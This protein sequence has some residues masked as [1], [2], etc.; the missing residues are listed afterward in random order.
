MRDA[1]ELRFGR[2]LLRRAPRV[3]LA[4]GKPVRLGA[5][6]I[7][8]L[9][10]LVDA[11][12][13]PVSKEE[14]MHR[15]WPQ[16]VVEEHNLTVQISALRAALG[17]DA[18]F[19][20]T[21]PRRGYAFT[22]SVEIVAAAPTPARPDAVRSGTA[23]PTNIPA[24]VSDLIGRESELL[25]LLELQRQRRLLT[26]TGPGGIGK[27]RLAVELA[28]RLL[29]E[30]DDGVWLLDLGLLGDAELLIASV[31]SVFGLQLAAA[32][33]TL[34]QVVTALAGKRLLLVLD[35]CEHL[36]V[37]AANM[38][39]VL[40]SRSASLAIVATSREQLRVNGESV[41]R[42]PP[43]GVPATALTLPDEILGC[44][45]ARLF[46]AR[47]RAADA[48]FSAD[49]VAGKIGAICRRL[50]GI[51]LAIELA[52]ARAVTLGA[53]EVLERLD[54]RFRL[55]T[56]GRRTA[57]P[58][59]Q[60]LRAALDWSYDLLGETEQSV[61]RGLGVFVGSF[62]LGAA[63]AVAGGTGAT[64]VATVECVANLVA[65]S[66]VSSTGEITDRR[67][68]LLE[69]TRS[70]MLTRLAEAGERTTIERRHAEYYRDLFSAGPGDPAQNDQH[71]TYA[72]EI[73]NIRAALDW[74]LFEGGD[75][76]I[77]IALAAALTPLWVRMSL[78]AEATR[79][80]RQALKLLD[81]RA[82]PRIEMVLNAAFGA[83]LTY[84]TGPGPETLAAWSKALRLAEDL[85][86][87]EYVLRA[88]RG[89]WSFRMNRGEY[90]SALALAN[91][92]CALV[93][94]APDAAALRAG[95]RMAGLILHYLGEQQEARR[96][97]ERG[98]ETADRP[99]QPLP[100]TRFMLN[101]TVAAR[102][103]LARIS[104]LQGFPDRAMRE[105]CDALRQAQLTGHAL[106]QCHALAQAACPVALWTGDL[107]AMDGFVTMLIDL[108]TLNAL[109]GWIARGKCFR[110]ALLIRSGQVD[111]GAAM[112]QS[113]L[114]ELRALGSMAE[115]PAFRCMLALGLARAGR[116]G[117]GRGVIDAALRHSATIEESWCI[118]ELL[119]ADGEILLLGTAPDVVA[120]EARFRQSMQVARRQ[121]A[122][123]WELR[124]V[125]AL[126]ALTAP[127]ALTALTGLARRHG[128]A[129]GE[130]RLRGGEARE[131]L[132]EVYGRF[133]EGFATADLQAARE[134]LERLS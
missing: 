36:I 61:L 134:V 105:A 86:D 34:E 7:E 101:E 6:A 81:A 69:T 119:R 72:A 2:F 131:L 24:P 63:T 41:Y 66:L 128:Q 32:A 20:R 99:P 37:A 64:Q 60:T 104:W 126:T 56:G 54:D 124:S 46:L 76:A 87:T 115:Y 26:L 38:A 49:H 29:P 118:A 16:A 75:A 111:E 53:E 91:Q 18:D 121:G 62:T 96:R 83:A 132:A 17:V 120:A 40:L 58:R 117:E 50:D 35:N 127:T 123:A 55:L 95:N 12:G 82:D 57:L 27:T 3:L 129:G 110:G 22:A 79:Y 100:M 39:E 77:G 59:Q 122:L 5:R 103:L 51:P 48:T 52:A 43:L 71:A 108:A 1:E 74:A 14:L 19:I 10:M 15:A 25:E 92:F 23:A 116:V 8:L 84:T 109:E 98:M 44:D 42:V 45:A 112:L 114:E 73:D 90:R 11:G 130:D 89:M 13:E 31:A 102:A 133:S 68:R 107:D 85:R 94:R 78:M 67:F 65:K 33:Q 30:F 88:L 9:L 21:I 97:I 80:V 4:D 113:A 70:Y 106:S 28:R 93:E 47:T 125:T